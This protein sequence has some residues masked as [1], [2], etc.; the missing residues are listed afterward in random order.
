MNNVVSYKM[1][2]SFFGMTVICLM[3]WACFLRVSFLP[4]RAS[5][6]ACVAEV[7]ENLWKTGIAYSKVKTAV[8]DYFYEGKPVPLLT[9]ASESICN[10]SLNAPDLTPVNQFQRHTYYILYLLAPF[11]A[12]FSGES[13]MVFSNAAG[14]CLFLIVLWFLLRSLQISKIPAFLFCALVV[15]HPAWSISFIYGQPYPDRLFLPFILAALF[16]MTQKRI[17]WLFVLSGFLAAMTVD[18]AAIIGGATIVSYALLY[19]YREHQ[20]RNRVLMFGFVLLAFG[21]FA[22]KVIINTPFAGSF[23]SPL[24]TLSFLDLPGF[25]KNVG[26][27]LLLNSFLLLFALV[28]WRAFLIAL[29]CMFPNIVGTMGGAEKVG[30]GTHYHSFYFPVL[31]WAGAMGFSRIFKKDRSSIR[32]LTGY[33][34]VLLLC[35]FSLLANPYP[36]NN[37]K[38]RFSIVNIQKYNAVA[39]LVNWTRDFLGP[40]SRS[41]L[42]LHLRSRKE[43]LA[44]VP[45]GV[46][47]TAVQGTITA[48]FPDR[49]VYY[50]PQGLDDADYAVVNYRDQENDKIETYGLTSYISAVDRE[51][52]ETC[53]NNRL[54][55][56]F[57][58][59]NAKRVPGERLL[60]LKR[61]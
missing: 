34:I 31:V 26:T 22:I 33:G 23:V 5:D 43:L 24:L 19:L 37:W 54:R 20:S 11:T 30:W 39:I 49:N 1:W 12:A 61:L 42:R 44:L 41:V 28:D 47:V 10:R 13:V 35:L 36:A 52:A 27:F 25:Y 51:K 17:G 18:R 4:S 60:I 48:L 14:F 9:A 21:F 32:R 29:M 56:Q 57:D 38:D 6:T 40:E 59:E 15:N 45:K 7:V 8:I 58:F 46:S 53:L 50:Y 55:E 16:F 3:L 2:K